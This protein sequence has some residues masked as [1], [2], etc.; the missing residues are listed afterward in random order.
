MRRG[1][2]AVSLVAAVVGCSNDNGTSS[3]PLAPPG[4]VIEL[5]VT[6]L[7][8]IVPATKST[9]AAY[10]WQISWT[11]EVRDTAGVA[12]SVNF[13]QL[14]IKDQQVGFLNAGQIASLAGSTAVPANGALRV[15]ITLRYILPGNG[16]TANL[17]ITANV[18]DSGGHIVVASG[19]L[20]IV[21]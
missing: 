10:S 1:W 16:K 8:S 12:G 4:T 6:P 7:P 14:T 17:T 18:T 11:T 5:A 15:P 21:P 9:D 19:T 2:L 20:V 13:M 3:T